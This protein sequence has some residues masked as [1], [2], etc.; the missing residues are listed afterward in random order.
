[1]CGICG[2][3]FA[4][5]ESMARERLAAEFLVGIEERGRH[6]TGLA[7]SAGGDVWID[8]APE[9]ATQFVSHLPN[10]SETGVFIGHTRWASQ[11]SPSNPL[12][13]HPIDAGGLVG[14]HNGVLSN[15]D[16]LFSLIGSSLRQGEVDSEA[17]FA[18]I[19]HSGM[20]ITDS[21]EWLKGSAAIAWIDSQDPDVLH[22]ARVASSPLVVA[23]TAS[24]SLLFASTQKCLARYEK[25]G[26]V[27]EQCVS[28]SEGTYLAVQHGEIVESKSFFA[29]EARS[30]TATERKAL[31]LD[32][33]S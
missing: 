32:P 11:G 22:L 31:H 6:A 33:Q 30:L 25:F 16:D 13:N 18:F 20:A 15:D 12:N 2:A 21:L 8:K 4:P 28:L 1:M 26:G 10:M 5:G 29:P 24:G 7:W 17:I 14:I 19:A 9:T 3:S 27:I 23:F